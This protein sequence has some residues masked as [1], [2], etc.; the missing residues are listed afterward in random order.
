M[1]EK[2]CVSTLMKGCNLAC[3]NA[4]PMPTAVMGHGF[5]ARVGNDNAYSLPHAEVKMCG[6]FILPDHQNSDWRFHSFEHGSSHSCP[7]VKICGYNGQDHRRCDSRIKNS[8]LGPSMYTCAD[9][10]VLFDVSMCYFLQGK[11]VIP[12]GTTINICI[13]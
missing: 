13:M 10:C 5:Y 4:V 8:T 3:G 6:A 12:V 9:T 7:R 11:T 2:C 1:E